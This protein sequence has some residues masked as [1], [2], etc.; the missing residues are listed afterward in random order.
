MFATVALLMLA[1]GSVLL[2][3]ESPAPPGSDASWP[4][5]GLLSAPSD[6]FERALAVRE[7]R[8]PEDHGPHPEFR[9]EWWYFSGHLTAE[10]G[11]RFG[12]QL[13]FFRFGLASGNLGTEVD[14]P[15]AWVSDQ[16]FM[17]HLAVTDVQAAKF[18][19][20]ERFSRG[21]AIGLAGARAAPL[22]VWLDDWEVRSAA[23]GAFPWRLRARSDDLRIE[24]DLER[25]KPPVLHAE[26]GL[27]RK[28]ATPGNASYYY[29]LPRLPARGQVWIAGEQFA[30]SGQAW[31]D[32]EWSS[33]A[34][35]SDQSGWDWFAL[36][37]AD[38]HELMVYLLRDGEGAVHPFSAGTLVDPAGKATRL[39]RRDIQI[40][41]LAHWTSPDGAATYPAQWRLVVPGHAI[42]VVVRPQVADQEHRGVFRYWE[43]AASFEG[44]TASGPASG[45]AYVELTGYA[46]GEV[47]RH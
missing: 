30:V 23:G 10:N 7:F 45:L 41:V 36:Q 38:G 35:E 37:F 32:R 13:T 29:S 17:A 22:A 21:G 34:L 20:F 42:D 1:A 16:V 46:N 8:F 33:S 43:G 11:R 28:S 6:A 5:T 3:R 2:S 40:E 19:S 24:L 26:Q 44:V 14:R 12:F 39:G 18:L 31:L 27:S 15:S 25:G 4:V 47:A 9:N